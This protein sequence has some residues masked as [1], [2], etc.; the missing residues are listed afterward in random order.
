MENARLV[1]QED[2][3]SRWTGQKQSPHLEFHR[4]LGCNTSAQSEIGYRAG[5]R[6]HQGSPSQPRA[7][8]DPV[9]ACE[10]QLTATASGGRRRNARRRNLPSRTRNLL[11]DR[12]GSADGNDFCSRRRNA[13]LCAHVG[14]LGHQVLVPL[15]QLSLALALRRHRRGRRVLPPHHRQLLRGDS[16]KP[17]NIF[18]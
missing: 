17:Y 18:L 1:R 15:L 11:P 16:K 10:A 3:E 6:I 9:H 13:G 12:C 5:R 4:S 8:S 2:L 7:S 14:A